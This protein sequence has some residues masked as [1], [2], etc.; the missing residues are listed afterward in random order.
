MSIDKDNNV[1]ATVTTNEK[2]IAEV[3][4]LPLGNYLQRNKRTRRIYKS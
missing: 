4:D 2:G 1:V 3:K